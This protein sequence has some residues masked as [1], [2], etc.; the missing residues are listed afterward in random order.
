MAPLTVVAPQRVTYDSAERTA[1]ARERAAACWCRINMTATKN[2]CAASRWR[3]HRE[4]M[5]I[6]GDVRTNAD[7]TLAERSDQLTAI[8]DLGLSAEAAVA[9]LSLADAEWSEVAQEMPA[10]LSRV[11]RDE[12]RESNLTTIRRRVPSFVSTFLS[13][14]ASEVAIVLVQ[15][16]VRPNSILNVE[17]TEQ[18]RTEARGSRRRPNCH[19]GTGRGCHPCRRCGNPGADRGLAPTGPAPTR[20]GSVDALAGDSFL[21][22]W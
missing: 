9:V 19:P 17:R 6:I 11:M 14:P 21:R 2:A 5:T 13:E 16:L 3:V 10:A 7:A 1:R 8:A 12:I 4:V 20:M 18:L 15:S 22:P